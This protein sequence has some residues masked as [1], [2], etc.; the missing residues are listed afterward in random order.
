ML[1]IQTRAYTGDQDIHSIVALQAAVR[2]LNPQVDL[3]TFEKLRD[4][5][6]EPAFDKSRDLRLWQEDNRLVMFADMWLKRAEDK[7]DGMLY[8][9]VLPDAADEQLHREAIAWGETRLRE[10]AA[11]QG[12][13]RPVLHVF[14]LDSE[15]EK[16][17]LWPELGFGVERYHF[18]MQRDLHEPI[19]EPALPDGFTLRPVAGLHEVGAWVDCF[20]LSFIDHYNF[21][22]QTVEDLTHWHNTDDYRPELDLVAVAEDGTFAAFNYC[23]ISPSVNAAQQ[24]SEGWIDALGTRR[25]YRKRGLGRA[26]LL[27]GMHALKQAGMDDAKL[28]VDAQ[29]PSGALRLYEA[30]GFHRTSTWV[31]HL[32][33]LTA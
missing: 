3:F 26:M 23:S 25:G 18:N 6:N 32:K 1:T 11:E 7:L 28:G 8:Y 21:H 9:Q 30:V 4:E 19:P 15:T 2:A 27:A 5:Y 14:G 29:N 24:R 20:N 22:P 13:L 12:G 16:L 10:A 31:R 33:E 17:R